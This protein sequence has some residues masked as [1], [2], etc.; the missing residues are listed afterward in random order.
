MDIS[1][2]AKTECASDKCSCSSAW[3]TVTGQTQENTEDHKH[4]LANPFTWLFPFIG[5]SYLAQDLMMRMMHF[6][7]ER[8][9]H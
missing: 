8:K 5:V 4:G 6:S 7:T 1:T 9:K 2:S 3:L